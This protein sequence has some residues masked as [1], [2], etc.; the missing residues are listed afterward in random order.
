MNDPFALSLHTVI[1]A[2]PLLGH[3]LE[4]RA[5]I[6][7]AQDPK[8]LSRIRHGCATPLRSS[9]QQSL[10]SV[11]PLDL[12]V[13]HE[14]GEKQFHLLEL[15]GTGI[16]GLTNLTEEAL[17]PILQGIGQMA[18]A[19]TAAD[20]LIMIAS[21]GKESETNPRLNRLI[22]EKLMYADAIRRGFADRGREATVLAMPTL[23]GEPESLHAAGPKIVVGYIKEF[24]EHVSVDSRGRLMLMGREVTGAVNDRFFLNV[25][26]HCG[27]SVDL[28]N[29]DVMNRCFM[30]GADKG[31]A[32][33]L[34]NDFLQTGDVPGFPRQVNFEICCDRES[35][36]ETVFD[37]TARGRRTVIKPH[38]TGLGHGI[39]FFLSNRE[40]D[41]AI[42]QRIDQSLRTTEEYYAIEGG[43]FPYTVCEYV[44]ADRIDRPGHRLHGHKYELRVVVYR[45]ADMLRAYPSIVKVACEPCDEDAPCPTG[46]INNITSSCVRT[47]A[48]GTD[49]MFPLANRETMDLFG[50]EE[51]HIDDLCRA[52]TGYVRYV[53]D[54]VEDCPERVGLPSNAREVAV[55]A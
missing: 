54:Q 53:L 29:L 55:A 18:S 31:I 35:L 24:L 36:I 46:L 39:E 27:C 12:L 7:T 2:S 6:R 25:L 45:D 38:G 28:A 40:S 37:W 51:R 8:L 21:S 14:A 33:D 19:D 9:S 3:T 49:F 50:L 15:N 16:G 41:S 11:A 32:Y 13:S 10:F 47:Q 48:K 34:L 1:A 20:P 23:A 44:D 30:A 43:A 52:A 4:D 22:Y 26:D 42:I 5:P 17:A